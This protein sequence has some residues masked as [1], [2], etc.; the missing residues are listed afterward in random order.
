MYLPRRM[1]SMSNAPTFTCVRLRS[2]TIARASAADLTFRG[3]ISSGVAFLTLGHRELF[4]RREDQL[5]APVE[6]E[7]KQPQHIEDRHSI[8]AV[9]VH[10]VLQLVIKRDQR[11]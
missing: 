3:S 8:N 2:E 10:R 11:D 7:I 4:F 5:V 9:A 6:G 1:P